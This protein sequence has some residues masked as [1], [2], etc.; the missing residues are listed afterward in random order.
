MLKTDSAV[1]FDIH[2]RGAAFIFWGDFCGNLLHIWFCLVKNL[3][4]CE[5]KSAGPTE[6][7]FVKITK[8]RRLWV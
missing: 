6:I 3:T 7:V 5:E 8:A 4:P 1:F 2:D